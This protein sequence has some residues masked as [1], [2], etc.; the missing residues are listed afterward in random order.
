MPVFFNN[1]NMREH[2]RIYRS[3][4]FYDLNPY[5]QQAGMATGLKRGEECVVATPNVFD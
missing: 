1:C 4:A 5:G 3:D 2:T